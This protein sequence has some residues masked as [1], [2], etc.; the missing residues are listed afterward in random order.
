MQA[1]KVNSSWPETRSFGRQFLERMA[2]AQLPHFDRT[3][4]QIIGEEQAEAASKLCI[5]P[6]NLRPGAFSVSEEAFIVDFG[7]FYSL[8]DFATQATTIRLRKGRPSA[9]IY[10]WS[11]DP[12]V[13]NRDVDPGVALSQLTEFARHNFPIF[14]KVSG[15]SYG[16]EDEGEGLEPT[17]AYARPGFSDGQHG[18]SPDRVEALQDRACPCASGRGWTLNALEV[19]DGF[20]SF[21][22][23]DVQS[24][25]QELATLV[26]QA[27]LVP[28]TVSL[29]P[30]L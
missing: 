23:M 16:L 25:T 5:V 4:E 20:R 1:A 24:V 15:A 10:G 17:Q 14:E 28:S 12:L 29:T 2:R 3:R 30:G 27:G 22:L 19:L 13:I 18:M 7:R 21:N 6:R 8:A 26:R 11:K 9:V